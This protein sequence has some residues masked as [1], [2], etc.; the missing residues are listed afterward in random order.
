MSD[1]LPPINQS[2][3][4][5]ISE[6]AGKPVE[7]GVDD[8]STWCARWVKR[9]KGIDLAIPSYRSSEQA[10][11]LIAASRGLGNVWSGVADAA[12]ISERIDA[13]RLGDVGIMETARFGEVG[14]IFGANGTCFWRAVNGT[15]VLTPR[16]RYIS[17]IW[18]IAS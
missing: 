14:I 16:A 10:I 1:I 17:K 7:W 4:D 12:C 15:R 11:A 5:F 3:I 18:S 2:L 8:C 9:W 13:P 6:T